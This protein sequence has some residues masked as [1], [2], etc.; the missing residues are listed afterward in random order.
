MKRIGTIEIKIA[1]D[2]GGIRT[3]TSKVELTEKQYQWW[4]EYAQKQRR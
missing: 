1:L 3:L 2:N 4:V